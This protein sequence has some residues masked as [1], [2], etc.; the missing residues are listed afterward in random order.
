MRINKGGPQTPV[1]G[2]DEAGASDKAAGTGAKFAEKLEKTAAASGGPAAD[3]SAGNQRRLTGDIGAA[4]EN[5][6]ISAEAAVD[7]VMNRILDNQMG[8]GTPAGTRAQVENALRE[9]LDSDPLLSAKLKN[10]GGS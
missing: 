5:K 2:A 4:L 9:A 3:K 10:L 6:E 1:G 8:A 7:Q